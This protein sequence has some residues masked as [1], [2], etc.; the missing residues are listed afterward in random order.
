LNFGQDLT[1][2]RDLDSEFR[3]SPS[4]GLSPSRGGWGSSFG[5]NWF[6]ADI[7]APLD[8]QSVAVAQLRV[9]PLMAGIS[10][11]VLR[12]RL[13]T[14]L[15]LIGGFAFNRVKTLQGLPAGVS[16]SLHIRNSWVAYPHVGLTYGITRRLALRGSVG[17]I[18]A[19]PPL[20]LRVTQNG[21]L[22]HSNDASFR[23]DYFN[24]GFGIGYAVF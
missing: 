18:F 9:R 4:V 17:Y 6:K 1:P 20:S 14:S 15:S 12:H 19:R 16:A 24:C 11:S 13:L 2:G 7:R 8:G 10:Y 5:L 22:V 23:G 3:V 21:V